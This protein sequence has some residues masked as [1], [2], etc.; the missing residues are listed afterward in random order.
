MYWNS[1]TALD[2]P[3]LLAT[4]VFVTM[5]TLISNLIVDLLYPVLDPRIT[6]L[7]SKE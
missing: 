7:G 5:T 6:Y 2:Y 4:T 3:V 1:I